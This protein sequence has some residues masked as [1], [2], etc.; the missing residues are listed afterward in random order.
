MKKVGYVTAHLPGADGEKGRSVLVGALLARGNGELAVKIDTLPLHM[1]EW[2]GWLN[3]VQKD[4]SPEPFSD[5]DPLRYQPGQ[6]G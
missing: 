3:I 2:K 1:S 4:T 6:G 5:D